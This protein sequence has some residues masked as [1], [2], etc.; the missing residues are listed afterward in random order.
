MNWYLFNSVARG[1][2]FNYFLLLLSSL[3]LFLFLSFLFSIFNFFCAFLFHGLQSRGWLRNAV[4]YS[5]WTSLWRWQRCRRHYQLAGILLLHNTFL[6]AANTM[7]IGCWIGLSLLPLLN[8]EHR[9]LARN[10]FIC[11][12]NLRWLADYL[13]KNPIETSGA[14]CDAP[15]RMHRRRIEA[16]RDEKF[17]CKFHSLQFIHSLVRFIVCALR[18]LVCRRRIH[19]I[20]MAK[21]GTLAAGATNKK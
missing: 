16:L 4:A 7:R 20:F 6:I 5:T 10:P 13:H 8:T 17:K 15:K 18:C 11:D 21:F 2:R 19:S 1:D 9:H 12:C 3:I 14:R